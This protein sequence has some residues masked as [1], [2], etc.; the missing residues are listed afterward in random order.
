LQIWFLFDLQFVVLLMKAL[1]M[2]IKENCRNCE[3]TFD[4]SYEYCPYCGQEAIDNLTVGVLFSNTIENYFSIDARFFRSF[5]TLMLKPGVLARRFVDGKRLKYLHPAQ[6][7]LFI[8]VIFFF[9]FS[10]TVRQADTEVSQAIKKGFEQE[11]N[12][13]AVLINADT[14]DMNEAKKTLKKNQKLIGLSDEELV[15]LDSVMSS[16]PQLANITFGFKRE[17]LDSLISA[18]APLNQKFKAMGMKEDA[19]AFSRRFYEQML[20]FYEKQGG[21]ILQ[22]LYDTIPI[23]MFLLLP[24]FA[25]FLKIFYWKP[26]TFAHHLVFSFYFFTFIFASFSAILLT[27]KVW[28]IPIAIEVLICFSFVIYL[29]FALRNFYRSSWKGAFFKA[30]TISFLYMLIIVPVAATGIILVAFMLY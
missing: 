4:S 29:M 14:L 17:L 5:A 19:N 1:H 8:S 22:V 16:D 6:F 3:H 20:K 27:N 30:N 10:F 11:D 7:Y 15:E 23:A 12:L 9:I 25:L 28:Q 24:L 13:N 26:A 2:P 21:G 18:G